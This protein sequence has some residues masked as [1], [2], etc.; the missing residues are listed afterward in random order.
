MLRWRATFQALGALGCWCLLPAGVVATTATS[1]ANSSAMNQTTGSSGSLHTV[2]STV[3]LAE[4]EACR[5]HCPGLTAFEERMYEVLQDPSKN[6]AG[7]C[8][9]VQVGF[10]VVKCI[11]YNNTICSA[12]HADLYL[13]KSR[14]SEI[15]IEIT[16]EAAQTSFSALACTMCSATLGASELQQYWDERALTE[17]EGFCLTDASCAAYDYDATR[18]RC[19]TWRSCAEAARSTRFGCQWTTYLKPG[20]ITVAQTPTNPG[21]GAQRTPDDYYQETATTTE[22]QRA[23]A[24]ASAAAPYSC[25]VAS[26]Q[27]IGIF[28]M[29]ATQYMRL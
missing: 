4:A 11:M 12:Y 10:D 3:S 13:T 1:I 9:A 2:V 21:I 18:S 14:C 7:I 16:Q 23:I 17:C 28:C 22:R 26:W 6:M 5:G 24:L 19:R 25:I 20:F 27:A 15:G 29:L 8:R